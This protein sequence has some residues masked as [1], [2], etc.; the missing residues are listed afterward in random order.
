VGQDGRSGD[1][2][3]ATLFDAIETRLDA[4]TVGGRNNGVDGAMRYLPV[5]DF[6]KALK[7]A[8]LLDPEYPQG[9]RDR[10]VEYD[11][12]EIGE[13]LDGD[14]EPSNPRDPR[15]IRTVVVIVRVGWVIGANLANFV[16]A[17]G[18]EVK[19][20]CAR[21]AKKRA[22]SEGDRMALALS[23]PDLFH[24]ASSEPRLTDCFRRGR[25]VWRDVGPGAGATDSRYVI[26]IDRNQ[27]TPMR[28]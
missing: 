14:T 11:W 3:S 26:T 22:L 10:A 9:A 1:A 28:P 18:A 27:T 23:E 19:V 13:G 6:R 2:V 8:S 16:Q 20:D 12:S 7:T 24:D 21:D 17:I 5:G 15:A 25:T 4:I